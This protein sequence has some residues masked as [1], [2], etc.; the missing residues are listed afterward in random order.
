MGLV[1]TDRGI[2]EQTI[3]AQIKIIPKLITNLRDPE[4]KKILQF[5]DET[6]VVLGMVLGGIIEK[7]NLYYITTHNTL[8]MPPDAM[9]ETFEI[10]LRRVREIRESIFKCG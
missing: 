3:D 4:F 7:F 2:L 5:K 1:T 6:D 10:T 9:N 8:Q